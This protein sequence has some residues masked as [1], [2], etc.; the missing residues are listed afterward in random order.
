MA[1]QQIIGVLGGLGPWATLD[2]FEKVLRATPAQRDQDHLRVIIDNNPKIPD[3]TPAIL[4]RGEDP[5]PALIATARNLERAGASFLVIPCNTAHAFYDQVQAAV[6]IPILHIMEEVATVAAAEVPDLKSV[7]VL[8]TVA[9]VRGELYHRPFARRGVT[10]LQPPLPEQTLV[11]RG[12]YQVKAGEMGPEVTRPLVGVAEGLVAR[13]AQALVLGCTE[14][15]FVLKSSHVRV[16]LF[17]SNLI[18]ARAAVRMA[19]TPPPVRTH[20]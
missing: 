6:S 15:P 18:L 3:R 13:G 8:A 5:V 16:P 9:T 4:G 20:R 1:E 17:D 2:F 12:I 10:V 19:V 14:L 11:D 7:G